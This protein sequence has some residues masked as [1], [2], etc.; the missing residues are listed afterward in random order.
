MRLTH[1]EADD[2]AG[3]YVLDALDAAEAA[4]VRAHLATC[5]QSH[6]LFADLAAVTPSLASLAEPVNAPP[7]LRDR[8]LTAVSL[9]AQAPLVTPQPRQAAP[10]PHQLRPAPIPS[11]PQGGP[12]PGQPPPVQAPPWQA[13]PWQAPPGQPPPGWAPQ[14]PPQ[15][16]PQPIPIEQAREVRRSRSWSW[17]GL[18][19]AAVIA[20]VALGVWNVI[21][22][23]QADE[24][25]DLLRTALAT[26]LDPNAEAARMEGSGQAAGAT[27]CAAFPE[28]GQGFIVMRGLPPV[29]ADQTYQAWYVVGDQP[30]S[31]GLMPVGPDGVAILTGLTP[32]QGTGAVALSLEPAGGSLP[33]PTGPIVAQGVLRVPA[34]ATLRPPAEATLAFDR[35]V[36]HGRARRAGRLPGYAGSS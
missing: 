10:P 3:L 2:L 1:E 19:A 33:L 13:P 35:R 29:E 17:L 26:C 5:D 4:A 28:S 9:T 36:E 25:D 22:Q 8:V 6:P 24:R 20:I 27:G 23:R 12:P 15:P 21:L 16:Y 7:A 30:T 31:A 32:A 11:M 14:P 18:A 34:E